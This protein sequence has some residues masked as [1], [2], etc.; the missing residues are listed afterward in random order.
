MP[1]QKGQKRSIDI[2][3]KVVEIRKARGHYIP[4]NKGR[5]ETRR[6]VLENQGKAHRGLV[7]SNKGNH[8]SEERLE[9]MRAIRGEKASN[10]KGGISTQPGYDGYLQ[11]KRR[12]KQ[13]GNGGFHTFGEW[14]ILKIQY[15]FTCLACR[16][17]E[18]EIKLTEDHIIPVSKGGS[19]YIENIQPL[20]QS[21]NSKKAT[22][23]IN[24]KNYDD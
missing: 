9:K 16:K 1:F 6:E 3:K 11:L 13:S 12:I 7:S 19:N 2:V 22:K 17:S 4:W 10:W 21:C 18:P 15:N 23:I 8:Y 24:Y 5:K 14:Q 20:C